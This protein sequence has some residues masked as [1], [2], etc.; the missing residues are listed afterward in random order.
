MVRQHHIRPARV[1]QTAHA[2]LQ[3]PLLKNIPAPVW[4]KALEQV[5]PAEIRT[6]PYLPQHQPLDPRAKKPRNLYKPTKLT[7]PEDKLRRE[8]YRDHPWEL[9]RP[10]MVL[11]TNGMDARF[12][13]WSTGVRQPGMKLSGE[14]VVQRQMWLMEN[15]GLSKE[16]A[17]D[18]ARR[19][20]YKLRHQEE[21]DARIAVEEARMVGAYF[22]KT[23]LQVG[24][25]IEGHQYE[26]WKSWATREITMS[27]SSSD[28][29]LSPS[30][31]AQGPDKPA[32]EDMLE[33]AAVP[34]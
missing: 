14:C 27:K 6:R 32:L 16:Q 23:L 18:T 11:E 21:I 12:R 17:Y 1:L 19:E 31:L 4:V 22:G 26:N 30:E 8:F 13:D 10:M 2:V 33:E 24:V 28:S 34:V 5:T 7:F 25:E 29:A 3:N 9:A 20:F 15:Q